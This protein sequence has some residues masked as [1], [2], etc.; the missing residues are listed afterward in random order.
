MLVF[1]IK[2]ALIFAIL[3]NCVNGQLQCTTNCTTLSPDLRD[4]GKTMHTIRYSIQQRSCPNSTFPERTTPSE[5]AYVDRY[6]KHNHWYLYDDPDN[7]RYKKI[8]LNFTWS[9]R[10]DGSIMYLHGYKIWLLRSPESGKGDEIYENI[11]FCFLHELK[12]HEHIKANFYYD[13]F[14]YM[15]NINIQP[16]QKLLVYIRSMPEPLVQNNDQVLTFKIDIPSCADSNLAAVSACQQQNNLTISLINRTCSN[17]TATVAYNVPSDFGKF[18]FL[19]FGRY[20]QSNLVSFSIRTWKNQPLHG[21]FTV[22]LPDKLNFSTKYTLRVWGDQNRDFR[23]KV[24]FNFSHCAVKE[25]EKMSSDVTVIIAIATI[26]LVVL[27]IVFILIKCMWKDP[28]YFCKMFFPTLEPLEKPLPTDL[29]HPGPTIKEEQ[30]DRRT[31]VYVIF[32]DDHSKHTEVVVKFVNY[33]IGDLAFDVIFQLYETKQVYTDP[34]SWMMESIEK[35]DKII[36]IWSPEAARR[37]QFSYQ[38]TSLGHDFFTPVL[39]KIHNDLFLRKNLLKYVFVYFDY[40]SKD[41][42]PAEFIESYPHLHFKLMQQLTDFYFRL[43]GKE[44]F[45]PGAVVQ[46]KK[47]DGETYFD[48]NLTGN[49]HGHVLH[50]K[51]KEMIAYAENNPN[52]WNGKECSNKV[53]FS[54]LN[55]TNENAFE[56]LKNCFHIVPPDSLEI[57][58]SLELQCEI[59]NSVHDSS[60]SAEVLNDF[61]K[62]VCKNESELALLPSKLRLP[63]EEYHKLQEESSS[64]LTVSLEDSIESPSTKGLHQS[65]VQNDSVETSHHLIESENVKCTEVPVC[66]DDC[67]N[68]RLTQTSSYVVDSDKLSDKDSFTDGGELRSHKSLE[69]NFSDPELESDLESNSLFQLAPLEREGDPMD[70]LVSINLQSGII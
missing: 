20:F 3:Q 31:K 30:L 41:D 56:I 65:I 62:I 66:Q 36:I 15:D 69:A 60:V 58:E 7:S 43:I 55:I 28:K 49:K 17:V 4:N 10:D 29:G 5:P 12:F 57:S 68:I 46:E 35:S 67:V 40:V 64:L 1:V 2:F 50:C 37:W 44:R 70:F 47:A 8:A 42:I 13:R 21:N 39:K 33:L 32:F 54:N 16:S 48:E 6:W 19:T 23:R 34:V 61:D 52:W 11:Y 22:V 45:L 59:D 24:D 53:S 25:N 9:P 26:A 14:G 51:I 63:A 27:T 18:A 38:T